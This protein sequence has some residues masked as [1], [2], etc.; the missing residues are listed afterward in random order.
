MARSSA[1]KPPP[2]AAPPNPWRVPSF[3][4]SVSFLLWSLAVFYFY[5]QKW[6][7]NPDYLLHILDDICG[8]GLFHR[9]MVNVLA[10]LAVALWMLWLSFQSGAWLCRKTFAREDFSKLDQWSVGGAAGLGMLAMGVMAL[11]AARL[12]YA[13]VFWGIGALLTLIFIFFNRT[14]EWEAG[15]PRPEARAPWH[16]VWMIVLF[17]FF[18][19]FILDECTPEIFYDALYYHIAVP[20]LYQIAHRLYSLPTLLFSNF[21]LTIQLIYGA[22]LTLG[23]EITAKFM[24]GGMAVMMAFGFIAFEKRFLSRG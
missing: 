6:A 21:V 24:H 19:L 4:V 16:S 12:W 22:A 9:Y 7:P 8:G 3:Y 11:G 10:S 23:S 15:A 2:P 1:R 13:G 20:R 17:L 18:F 14:P 5:F